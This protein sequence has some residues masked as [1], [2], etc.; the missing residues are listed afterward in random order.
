[1]RCLAEHGASAARRT[2]KVRARIPIIMGTRA[3]WT[4]I[5]MKRANGTVQV[6]SYVGGASAAPRSS[7]D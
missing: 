1:M 3:M 7:N 6:D 5:I 2:R 4:V